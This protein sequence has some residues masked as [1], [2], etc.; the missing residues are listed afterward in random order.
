MKCGSRTGES[1]VEKND[2]TG[3]KMEPQMT[4]SL[5]KIGFIIPLKFNTHKKISVLNQIWDDYPYE[6]CQ[7]MYISLNNFTIINLSHLIYNITDGNAV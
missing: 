7:H 3:K 1:L 5:K 2:F 4:L 6:T